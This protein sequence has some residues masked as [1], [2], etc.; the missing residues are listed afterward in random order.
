MPPKM[1]AF[2]YI[3]TNRR[4]FVCSSAESQVVSRP[5]PAPGHR[6]AASGHVSP[7]YR[8]RAARRS[9]IPG[10]PS[11]S[12]AAGAGQARPGQCR[13]PQAIEALPVAMSLPG[14][15]SG[16][17]AG[18]QHPVSSRHPSATRRRVPARHQRGRDQR[19]TAPAGSGWVRQAA[20]AAQQGER[21]KI[22]KGSVGKIKPA[23]LCIVERHGGYVG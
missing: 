4:R 6:G 23:N 1:A 5:L 17:P 9:A 8:I 14:T 16:L 19:H 10:T 21:E 18:L 15:G 2:V 22:C 20:P 12:A 11:G 13:P 3:N 7:W